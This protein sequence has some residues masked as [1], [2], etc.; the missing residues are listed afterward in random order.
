MK[1]YIILMVLFVFTMIV[2]NFEDN[3]D[4]RDVYDEPT[5][6]E[7]FYDNSI[8]FV[9]VDNPDMRDIDV[10]SISIVF[11]YDI[12][13]LIMLVRTRVSKYT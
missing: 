2:V 13:L 12:A 4:I 7:V 3:I 8:S 9:D 11:I 5:S 6:M 10:E 1:K